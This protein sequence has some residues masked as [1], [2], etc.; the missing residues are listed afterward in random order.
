MSALL[1]RDTINSLDD[2]IGEIRGVRGSK[3]EY[4]IV[5]GGR[6]SPRVLAMLHS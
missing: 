6:V 5:N 2:V 1:L 3:F 4:L